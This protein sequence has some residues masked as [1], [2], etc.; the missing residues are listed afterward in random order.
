MTFVIQ[1][2]GLYKCSGSTC[3]VFVSIVTYIWQGLVQYDGDLIL[4]INRLNTI[5]RQSDEAFCQMFIEQLLKESPVSVQWN[6]QSLWKKVFRMENRMIFGFLLTWQ[7]ALFYRVML[8]RLAREQLFIAALTLER[9]GTSE[10]WML[11]QMYKC[12][13]VYFIQLY[14]TL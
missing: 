1:F 2:T 4:I 12:V 6:G 13:N 5:N 10:S 14:Y 9:S 8:K 11:L 3:C 7:A